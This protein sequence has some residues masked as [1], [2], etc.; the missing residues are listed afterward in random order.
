[1]DNKIE[2]HMLEN[3]LWSDGEHTRQ[4]EFSETYFVYTTKHANLSV[5]A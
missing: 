3:Q 5:D 2:K 4:A 1:M